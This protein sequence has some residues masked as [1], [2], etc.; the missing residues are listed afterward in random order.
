MDTANTLIATALVAAGIGVIAAVVAMWY[1]RVARVVSAKGDV[2]ELAQIVGKIASTQRR[3]QMRRVRAAAP[4][5]EGG[6]GTF[7]APPELRAVP[8]APEDQDPQ[9]VKAA[10]RRAL[11]NRRG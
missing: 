3:E 1:A 5:A 7:Q 11:F 2:D 10:L 9:A 4:S 6:S 8:D